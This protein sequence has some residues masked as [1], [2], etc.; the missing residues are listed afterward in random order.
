MKRSGCLA[1]TSASCSVVLK[2]FGKKSF[3]YV[4]RKIALST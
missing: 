2:P 4:G 3:K 1:A